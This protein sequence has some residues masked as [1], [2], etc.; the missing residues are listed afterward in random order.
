MRNIFYALQIAIIFVA[1]GWAH[2]HEGHNHLPV[3]PKKAVEIALETARTAS[4]TAQPELR[5]QQLD[6]SWRTLPTEAAKIQENGRGY[7]VVS[8]ENKAQHKT[9]YVRI[10]LNGQITDANFSGKFDE[11]P[12]VS[13]PR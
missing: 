2:A 7:Y 13:N 3:S 9:L 12:S 1:S 11:K 4:E 10:L 5:L 8:V 6:D